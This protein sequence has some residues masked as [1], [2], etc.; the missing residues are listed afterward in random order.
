[1]KESFYSV[2]QEIPEKKVVKKEASMRISVHIEEMMDSLENRIKKAM[3]TN[4]SSFVKSHLK[5]GAD[6]KELRVYRVVG[7]L[8]MLE[9]VK[10]GIV[11]V[12]Q[13]KNFTSIYIK[14]ND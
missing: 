9:L 14:N 1:M 4:F 10:N 2:L 5:E 6:K 3:N 13:E 11:N 8:A 12:L 7:F